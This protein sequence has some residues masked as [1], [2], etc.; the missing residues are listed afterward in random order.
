VTG[1]NPQFEDAAEKVPAIMLGFWISKI[2]ATPVC[3]L[4]C[5]G[6]RIA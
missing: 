2:L 4:R 1:I 5:A 6:Y 3:E